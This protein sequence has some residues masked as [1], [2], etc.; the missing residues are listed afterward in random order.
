MWAK[1]AGK[2]AVA[3]G[4]SADRMVLVEPYSLTGLSDAWRFSSGPLLQEAR[5]LP[6]SLRL[7]AGR[8]F[9]E[10]LRKSMTTA[11]SPIL[12][13]LFRDDVLR[14]SRRFSHDYHL[15]QRVVAVSE[16]LGRETVAA[17]RLLLNRI[18][19]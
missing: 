4:G 14:G 9:R 12:P 8:S 7:Q 15:N 3:E 17:E 18:L 1:V 11:A 10:F 6:L 2:Q 5:S 13:T 16:A 19:S